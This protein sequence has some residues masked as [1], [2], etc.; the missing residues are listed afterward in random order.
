MGKIGERGQQNS[1]QWGVASSSNGL[2]LWK[3]REEVVRWENEK[4][5]IKVLEWDDM[6]VRNKQDSEYERLLSVLD[7]KGN[8]R[9]WISPEWEHIVQIGDIPFILDDIDTQEEWVML[10]YE[11]QKYYR[12]EWLKRAYEKELPTYEERE[13]AKKEVWWIKNLLSLTHAWEPWFLTQEKEMRAWWY[14]F[15]AAQWEDVYGMHI[16]NWMWDNYAWHVAIRNDNYI[17]C[18]RVYRWDV[19][20]IE[21]KKIEREDVIGYIGKGNYIW[22]WYKTE[23]YVKEVNK[24]LYEAYK[25]RMR[26]DMRIKISIE[27]EELQ[28]EMLKNVMVLCMS[29][30]SAVD[31]KVWELLLEYERLCLDMGIEK[32]K[33]DAFLISFFQALYKPWIDKWYDEIFIMNLLGKDNACFSLFSERE[34]EVEGGKMQYSKKTN[35]NFLTKKEVENLQIWWH[36]FVKGWFTFDYLKYNYLIGGKIKIDDFELKNIELLQKRLSMETIQWL[37]ENVKQ[38]DK[39]DPSMKIHIEDGW[40][41]LNEKLVWNSI[42]YPQKIAWLLHELKTIRGTNT[43]R[44][45]LSRQQ[46]KKKKIVVTKENIKSYSKHKEEL[47]KDIKFDNQKWEVKKEGLFLAYL[48]HG[49]TE[50]DLLK[51]FFFDATKSLYTKNKENKETTIILIWTLKNLSKKCEALFPLLKKVGYDEWNSVHLLYEWWY[52]DVDIL[53]LPVKDLQGLASY[54]LIEKTSKFRVK[55][56]ESLF[57]NYILP[58][59]EIL[60]ERGMSLSLLL[61]ISS[62]FSWN[63]K[64]IEYLIAEKKY[65]TKEIV[66]CFCALWYDVETIRDYLINQQVVDSSIMVNLI[67]LLRQNNYSLDSI[68]KIFYKKLVVI[69][70][71]IGG[72][73][74]FVNIYQLFVDSWV[75]VQELIKITH[76]LNW[77]NSDLLWFLNQKLSQEDSLVLLLQNWLSFSEAVQLIDSDIKKLLALKEKLWWSDE[78]ILQFVKSPSDM[79]IFVAYAENA[80]RSVS[81]IITLYMKKNIPIKYLIENRFRWSKIDKNTIAILKECKNIWIPFDKIYISNP[82]KKWTYLKRYLDVWYTLD[83]WF[84]Q[85]PGIKM[86]DKLTIFTELMKVDEDKNKHLIFLKNKERKIDDI[87]LILYEFWD[88]Q[89]KATPIDDLVKLYELDEIYDFVRKN[90]ITFQQWDIVKKDLELM[91]FYTTK[92]DFVYWQLGNSLGYTDLLLAKV[93]HFLADNED[94]V[95]ELVKMLVKKERTLE[96]LWNTWAL[97]GSSSKVDEKLNMFLNTLQNEFPGFSSSTLLKIII[98]KNKTEWAMLDKTIKKWMLEWRWEIN[99]QEY[100]G[101]VDNAWYTLKQKIDFVKDTEYELWKWKKCDQTVRA[102]CFTIEDIK[103]II[104]IAPLE[105]KDHIGMILQVWLWKNIDKRTDYVMHILLFLAKNKHN[106]EILME[107]IKGERDI[108]SFEMWVKIWDVL[109]Q[110]IGEKIMLLQNIWYTLQE[111]INSEIY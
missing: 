75:N 33:I 104:A 96:Q 55:P 20:K 43:P 82:D 109:F 60:I 105:H 14:S 36:R 34:K 2:V 39:I 45:N 83:E 53:R 72:A 15:Q 76:A 85:M 31:T 94:M 93:K 49:Y 68:A 87:Y 108:I 62:K 4:E 21:F 52:E 86:E 59:I 101:I 81:Q 8:I 111:I 91:K 25:N 35:I 56:D 10:E 102:L 23:E 18:K 89:N 17:W 88:K 42:E 48:T 110:N 41:L 69:S 13:Q 70:A 46:E 92:K 19:S 27:N 61:S 32:E 107:Y 16:A 97:S 67:Q 37:L 103:E 98:Q 63:S 47:L 30:Y 9:L 80:G 22:L 29:K 65:T 50:E 73:P 44:R 51:T 5:V 74:S 64:M 28:E 26:E 100:F 57:L 79:L 40:K 1:V 99:L 24:E 58:L 11:W 6:L 84:A 95:Q 3:G 12:I 77:S 78:Q 7:K 66:S 38:D 54:L 71:K 106:K 90:N